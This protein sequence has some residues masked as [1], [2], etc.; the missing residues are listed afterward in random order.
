MVDGPPK[1]W[2]HTYGMG[3]FR[4]QSIQFY[5]LIFPMKANRI[6]KRRTHHKFIFKKNNNNNNIKQ[7]QSFVKLRRIYIWVSWNSF[8]VDENLPLLTSLLHWNSSQK[9]REEMQ[10]FAIFL[11]LLSLSLLLYVLTFIPNE[12]GWKGG[13][14]ESHNRNHLTDDFDL[15]AYRTRSGLFILL[16]QLIFI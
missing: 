3:A 5:Q 2:P 8:W 12:K 14:L 7:K 6:I 10:T 9:E 15:R 4:N 16:F 1:P 13:V 11:N